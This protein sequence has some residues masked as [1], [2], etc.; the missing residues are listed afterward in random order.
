M[1]VY[2]PFPLTHLVSDVPSIIFDSFKTDLAAVG[3]VICIVLLHP[4][5]EKLRTPCG[6]VR[7]DSILESLRLVP[8]RTIFNL[9]RLYPFDEEAAMDRLQ[10]R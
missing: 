10:F 6:V 7:G 9:L 8:Q 5:S 2:R 1:H 4:G 3:D